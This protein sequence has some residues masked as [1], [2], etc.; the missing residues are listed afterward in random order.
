MHKHSHACARACAHIC[1]CMPAEWGHEGSAH[2]QTEPL[3][4]QNPVF[5]S[6]DKRW[7]MSLCQEL[8]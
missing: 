2:I 8:L 1:V 5:L 6:E 3:E 4:I 7:E